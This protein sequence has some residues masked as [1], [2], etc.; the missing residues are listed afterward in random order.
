MTTADVTFGD[1]YGLHPRA[2]MRIQQEAARFASTIRIQGLGSGGA[3][4]SAASMIS[5]VSAGIRQG[6]QVRV[7][8]EGPDEAEAVAALE[9]LLAAGV[10]HP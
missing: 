6:E 10:C 5:M 4:I 3:P 9:R 8:A 2:A 7:T 1:R